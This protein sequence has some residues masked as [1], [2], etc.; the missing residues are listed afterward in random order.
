MSAKTRLIGGR[1]HILQV[2]LREFSGGA[3][4]STDLHGCYDLLHEKLNE[5]AFNSRTDLLFLGADMCDRGPDSQ[6]VLDYL[7]EPWVYC[8]RGNHEQL[9]IATVEEG[10]NGPASRC[11][12]ENGGEWVF[13]MYDNGKMDEIMAIYETFKSLPIAIE[14]LTDKEKIG[15]VHAEVPYNDWDRFREEVHPQEEGIT[16]WARTNYDRGKEVVV[17]GVD[18]ILCGHTPTASGEVEVRGNIWYCDTGS[19]FTGNV[20]FFEI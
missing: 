4:F 3:F 14:L 15:I 17:G 18:R 13:D 5:F 10:F 6:Y 16:Q 11:L 2:D 7:N 19:F 1:G 8:I 20:A 9:F 12:W